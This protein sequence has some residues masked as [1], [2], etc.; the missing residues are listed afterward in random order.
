[1]RLTKDKIAI[2]EQKLA[3]EEGRL[4]YSG[5]ELEMAAKRLYVI[6]DTLPLFSLDSTNFFN[7][8]MACKIIPCNLSTNARIEYI[9]QS[10]EQLCI[11][12]DV[13]TLCQ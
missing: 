7:K 6:N 9:A 10:G 8:E 1:M 5:K 2:K 12:A 4:K 13:F 11:K 3:M